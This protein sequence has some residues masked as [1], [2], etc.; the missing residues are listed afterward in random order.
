M[1][2]APSNNVCAGLDGIAAGGYKFANTTSGQTETSKDFG[3]TPLSKI[4][5]QFFDL[6]GFTNAT[7][8]CVWVVDSSE[9]SIGETS[10]DPS[11]TQPERQLTIED[12]TIGTYR[13]EIV[14]TDP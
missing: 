5:V 1:Q 13:C 14:I 12:L 9:T 11:E 6:T 8:S 4:V 10:G 3:N 2:T 7:I